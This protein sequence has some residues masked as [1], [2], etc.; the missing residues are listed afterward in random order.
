MKSLKTLGLSAVISMVAFVGYASAATFNF[1]FSGAGE[2]GFGV[3]TTGAFGPAS[4]NAALV[5]ACGGCTPVGNAYAVSGITGFVNG[6]AITGL[7]T[8]NG[9]DNL[10]YYPASAVTITGYEA[11]P[12]FVDIAG[13]GWTTAT[14]QWN[15]GNYSGVGGLA[16]TDQNILGGNS[17]VLVTLSVTAVPEPATWAMMILGFLGMGFVA[18]R[19][20][21]TQGALRLA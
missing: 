3:L 20:K 7:A 10:L 4:S 17:G 1:S 2:S 8:W 12:T 15:L 16:V 11:P 21:N 13:L 6:D 18:Y 19:R 9:A 14:D 5:A